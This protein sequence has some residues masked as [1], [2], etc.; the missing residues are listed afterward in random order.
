MFI[1]ILVLLLSNFLAILGSRGKKNCLEAAF[2]VL[3]LFIGLKYDYGN[4]SLEYA[5]MFHYLAVHDYSV[6]DFASITSLDSHEPGWVWL[7]Y[8]FKPIGWFGFQILLAAFETWVI[9]DCTKRY[10]PQ[11]FQWLSVAIFTLTQSF[12]W[13]GACSMYRQWLACILF[14]FSIRFILDRRLIPFLLINIA[15]ALCHK[16]AIVV[17]PTYLF[18]YLNFDFIKRK[19]TAILVIILI[20]VWYLVANKY[21]G[22]LDSFLM[23][24]E[25]FSSYALTYTNRVNVSYSIIGLISAFAMPIFMLLNINR[26]DKAYTP[27][28]FISIFA[29]LF[30]PLKGYLNMIGRLATY[31]ETINIVLYPIILSNYSHNNPQKQKMVIIMILIIIL[32]LIRSLFDFFGA[33]AGNVWAEHFTN[34]NTILSQPWQ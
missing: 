33:G 20:A 31:F 6:F 4:D 24:S 19:S 18:A 12:M 29:L 15:G 10:V 9:Y 1:P 16:S 27:L 25:E 26:I 14:L 8:L 7:N 28:I 13:I 2:I 23:D 32:P 34:Y 3:F 22:S 21:F 5:Q 17:L 30:T 11:E